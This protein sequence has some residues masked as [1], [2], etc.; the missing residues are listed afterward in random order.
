MYYI[1]CSCLFNIIPQNA[2][3]FA[4]QVCTIQASFFI[5]FILTTIT[6]LQNAPICN[7]S[8][9]GLDSKRKNALKTEQYCQFPEGNP[10]LHFLND[11]VFRFSCRVNCTSE[12]FIF[13]CMHAGQRILH[14]LQVYSH[15]SGMKNER[16]KIRT[17]GIINSLHDTNVN[18]RQQSDQFFALCQYILQPCF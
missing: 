5:V 12:L 8:V 15:S 10:V 4:M 7:L 3:M 11:I 18:C 13:I 17:A 1:L 14:I 6:Q 16:F 2:F 9:C